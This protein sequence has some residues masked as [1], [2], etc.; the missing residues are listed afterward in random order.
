[1]QIYCKLPNTCIEV[2]DLGNGVSCLSTPELN[3]DFGIFDQSFPWKE[4]FA[5]LAN[6]Q[7]LKNLDLGL[8]GDQV[9]I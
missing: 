3:N 9:R 5:G 2:R 4:Q 1:M 7:T 8:G 6:S